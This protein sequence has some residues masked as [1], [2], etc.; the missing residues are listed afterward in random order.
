QSSGRA[1]CKTGTEAIHP[2]GPAYPAHISDNAPLSSAANAPHFRHFPRP[3]SRSLCRAVGLCRVRLDCR[4][5]T[6]ALGGRLFGGLLP[7]GLF[8]RAGLVRLAAVVGFVE[9]RP[10]EQDCSARAK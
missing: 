2:G 4:S 8:F 1:G 9:A 3:A 6:V 7:F 5:R 10:L